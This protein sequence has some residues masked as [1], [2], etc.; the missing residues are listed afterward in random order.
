MKEKA[1]NHYLGINGHKRKNCALSIVKAFEDKYPL[2]EY[3]QDELKT[4]GSGKAP[5]GICG[6]IYAVKLIL[7]NNVPGKSE[8]CLKKFAEK[9]GSLRCKEIR[10]L[11]KL[12]C[13]GCVEFSAELL[14][15]I[16][17]NQSKI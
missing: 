13:V 7:E 1:I 2:P 15:N 3:L 6:S 10:S 17:T 16:D 5:G 12:S 8:E 14:V 9:A 4:C 11:K